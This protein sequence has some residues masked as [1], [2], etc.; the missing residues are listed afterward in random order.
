VI[1]F[2]RRG[3]VHW[4]ALDPTLGREI[5]RTRP[6]LV[7][8]PDEMNR[9]LDTVI[10]APITS[11]VRDY[12][13]RV[14]IRLRRKAASVALDQVRCVSRARLVGRIAKI[15]PGEALSVLRELFSD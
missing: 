7:V 4:V 6:G 12:P 10:V 2:P 1:D 15:D 13:A 11:T 9:H 5:R 8:S 14:T 3:E